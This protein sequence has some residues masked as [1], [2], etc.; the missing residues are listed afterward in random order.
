MLQL[1]PYSLVL[2]EDV[3]LSFLL[4]CV[5]FDPSSLPSVLFLEW[6]TYELQVGLP[7]LSALRDYVHL[8]PPPGTLLAEDSLLLFRDRDWLLLLVSTDT[9]FEPTLCDTI[10][11]SFLGFLD[12]Q[13]YDL[14][15]KVQPLHITMPQFHYAH[16][17]CQTIWGIA[18]RGTFLQDPG[19]YHESLSVEPVLKGVYQCLTHL[20]RC[21]FQAMVVTHFKVQ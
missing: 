15:P 14:V 6:I 17:T 8:L 18:I 20:H 21:H 5:I 11:L 7:W 1:L 2:G 3:L 10:F 16:D 19:A 9:F 4:W 13:G 12:P